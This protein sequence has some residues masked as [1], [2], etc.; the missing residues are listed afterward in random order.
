[1]NIIVLDK[2]FSKKIKG[3][4]SYLLKDQEN[5][6]KNKF[7]FLYKNIKLDKVIY[8]IIKKKNKFIFNL[9]DLSPLIID[10]VLS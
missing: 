2:R 1:M 10:K 9:F 4:K 6:D 7:I 5:N 3:F 8:D